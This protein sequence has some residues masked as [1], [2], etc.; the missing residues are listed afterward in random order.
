MHVVVLGAGVVGI[1]TAYQLAR[2]G[3][4]VTVVDRQ[5]GPALETSF[6]NAAQIAA[7]LCGPWSGPGVPFKLWGWLRDPDSPLRFKPQADP[8]QWMW[9]LRFLMECT[10]AR[11][12]R[13]F[14][15]ML[16]FGRYSQQALAQVKADT[17]MQ[18]HQVEAGILKLCTTE[19]TVA[20]LPVLESLLGDAG[21]P[22]KRLTPAECVALEPALAQA[23]DRLTAGLHLPTDESGD[24]YLFTTKLADLCAEMGVAFRYGAT[25]TG[26]EVENGAIDEVET[27]KGA[28]EG[29]AFVLALGSYS[30]KLARQLGLSLPVWPV[31]GYS[32]T[33]PVGPGD[34]APRIS[35]YVAEKKVAMSRLGDNL[36]IAGMADIAGHDTALDPRRARQV[37]E[38]GLDI[39]PQAGDRDQ[40]RLWCGLRPLTPDGLPIL[41]RCKL[42]NLYLNTGHGTYGWTY[43]CGSA[44]VIADLIA[45]RTP[46]HDLSGLTLSRF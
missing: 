17:G 3:H 1:A 19:E 9:G 40:A 30:P 35:L 32:A 20:D 8:R 45:G 24:A 13:T 28:I 43:A 6:A 21:I 11:H 12:D 15:R 27:D 25:I 4:R 10:Q 38:A 39:F 26:F 23:R 44:R 5:P 36:R 14:R 46:E 37:L 22:T 41:G 33:V 31:K 2:Q 42:A 7:A 18:Y 16:E 29:D 34:S